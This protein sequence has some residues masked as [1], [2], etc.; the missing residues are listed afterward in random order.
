MK[1]NK[2]RQI[3]NLTLE[4]GKKAYFAS[5]VHLG[6]Y[7][8]EQSSIREKVF[9]N[10]LN[11]IKKDVGV[12]FLVGDIFDY[13]Y[14]YKKV[15]PRGFIRFL[16]KL[17]EITDSGVPVYFFT[18]NHDVWVFDYLPSETGVIVCKNPIEICIN[19]KKFFIGHG[20]GVGPGDTSYKLLRKI[21]HSKFLQLLFSRLH[22]NFTF[23][24]GQNWSKHSR[25]S[26]GLVEPYLGVEKEYNILFAK[27]YVK[28]NDIDYF[29]FGHRHIPM[30]I[31][32]SNYAKLINLGEWI[33]AYTFG[34]FDGSE[35]HLKSYR[36][37]E[38]W[39]DKNII[40]G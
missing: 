40:R 2:Y 8:Y 14:E 30:V 17:C 9:V 25:Y 34:V 39:N 7:P 19:N 1:T 22:P 36:K 32:I 12:L 31:N 27:D 10:W 13:W 23:A 16:G 18:G 21:F 15:A 4:P 37:P 26:K 6:L 5:D 3:K 33:V 29:I 35:M 20:D 11:E 28:N 38:G 24:L